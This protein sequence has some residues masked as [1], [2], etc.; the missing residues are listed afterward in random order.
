MMIKLG[1]EYS[2]NGILLLGT[3]LPRVL[4]MQMC[5]SSTLEIGLLEP[6]LASRRSWAYLTSKTLTFR[7]SAS[8]TTTVLALA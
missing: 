1:R 4:T 7:L 6:F 3:R 8:S 5:Y 2:V